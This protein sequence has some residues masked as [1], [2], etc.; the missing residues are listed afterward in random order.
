MCESPL[1]LISRGKLNQA[2]KVLRKAA[3]VN[4]VDLPKVLFDD[5]DTIIQVIYV[6][7]LMVLTSHFINVIMVIL[8][9]T[10]RKLVIKLV[11]W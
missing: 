10:C 3:K 7:V 2:E 6:Y 5:Q 4:K 1:W 9:H 11:I 8:E